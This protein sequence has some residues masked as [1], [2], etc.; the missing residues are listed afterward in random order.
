MI[1]IR[2][3]KKKADV[4][5]LLEGFEFKTES[6]I[7]K[8]NFFNQREGYYTDART[9]DLFMSAI[10]GKK[11]VVECYTNARTDQSRIL[12][13]HEGQ[14]HLDWLREQDQQFF[15]SSGLGQTLKKHDAEF[16][17]I[18]EE[19]WA[20]R[21]VKPEVI[22]EIVEKKFRPIVH[23]QLYAQVPEKLY[24]KRNST[25]LNLAKF[26][27]MNK[28]SPKPF[29]SL[30]MKNLFGLIADP[31]RSEYHGKNYSGLAGSINDMC[32]IY[33]AL[34]PAVHV[35]EAVYKTLMPPTEN[36]N[37]LVKNL[38]LALASDQVVA[39]DAFAVRMMNRNPEERHFLSLGA[40]S[41]GKWD[42]S[43]FPEIPE[44]YSDFFKN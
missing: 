27:A 6:V 29:F 2:E 40:E 8:P 32:K 11:Y 34:F 17:N 7:I 26:K 10:P 24:R 41:F 5:A 20:G 37:G 1:C 38:G 30:A 4:I 23:P 44:K 19:V 36:E 25:L 12:Q 13:P 16:I 18:T 15:K 43:S 21:T 31:N 39:I 9:L 42:E 14:E 28:A 35:L 22:S 33:C 3:I